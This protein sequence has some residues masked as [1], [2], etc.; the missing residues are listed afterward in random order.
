MS[1]FPYRNDLKIRF[2]ITFC[3][4]KPTMEVLGMK[5]RNEGL[6]G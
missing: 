3:V 1:K 5:E 2:S 4:Q 6:L